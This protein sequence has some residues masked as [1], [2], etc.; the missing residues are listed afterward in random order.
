MD[1][2]R[3]IEIASLGETAMKLYFE[4]F[5]GDYPTM[6]S[7]AGAVWVDYEVTADDE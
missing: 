2:N 4:Y 7:L 5:G 3:F 6:H 1:R